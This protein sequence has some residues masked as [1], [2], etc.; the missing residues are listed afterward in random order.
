MNN[1][2]IERTFNAPVE[3]LWEIWTEAE[4]I[5]Q[6]FGGDPNGT[7]HTVE[8]DV[9][10]GGSFRIN[11]SDS[12]GT[13]HTAFGKYQE[14]IQHSLLKYTWEWQ[15]EPGHIS[16]VWVVFESMGEQ[17]KITLTHFNLS[18]ESAH[19]YFAGW[20]AAIDKIV[21]RLLAVPQVKPK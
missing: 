10:P 20:N 4:Y 12:N 3:L 1:V 6:W 21:K 13:T 19:G 9:K 14:V 18:P 5:M 7:V 17:S 11:F 15:S 2:V 16:D 8:N